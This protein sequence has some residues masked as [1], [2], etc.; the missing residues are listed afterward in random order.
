MHRHRYGIEW[1]EK[2]RAGQ[3]WEMLNIFFEYKRR[4][5]IND[6]KI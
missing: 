3:G 1:H 4:F 5:A 2:D 6:N